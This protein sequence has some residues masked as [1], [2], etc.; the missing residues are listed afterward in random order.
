MSSVF[1]HIRVTFGNRHE[2]DQTE[3]TRMSKIA[4]GIPDQ[5]SDFFAASAGGWSQIL[6]TKKIIIRIPRGVICCLEQPVKSVIPR[7]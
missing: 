1:D 5:S 3:I 4:V 6:L 2:S 7:L